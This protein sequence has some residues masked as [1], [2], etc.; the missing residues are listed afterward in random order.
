MVKLDSYGFKTYVALRVGEIQESTK[1]D[2]WFWIEGSLNIADWVTRPNRTAADIKEGSIWQ[3]GPK[4]L[5]LPVEEWP[6]QLDVFNVELP[7]QKINKAEQEGTIMVVQAEEE[8]EVMINVDEYSSYV[9]LKRVVA[10]IIKACKGF[11]GEKVQPMLIP[12]ELAEAEEFLIKIAQKEFFGRLQENKFLRLSARIHNDITY[13]GG[14]AER[15]MQA[16]WN[17]QAFIL[18][19]SKHH[20]SYLIAKHEMKGLDI[21]ESQLLFQQSDL[22]IGYW[23]YMD[24]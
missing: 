20:L 4:F 18:L 9:K 5:K 22:S 14:R 8:L 6:T 2:E 7:D 17:R 1:P 24:L 3:E 16:T 10:W 21:W 12:K 15:W 23:A 13:V 11:K 19:P